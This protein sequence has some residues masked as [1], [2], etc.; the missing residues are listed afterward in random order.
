MNKAS[1]WL[2]ANLGTVIAHIRTKKS[3]LTNIYALSSMMQH[4]IHADQ[5]F[6][7]C[8]IVL[9]PSGAKRNA[10]SEQNIVLRVLYIN[11]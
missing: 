4:K 11:H 2:I 5:Y 9:G 10:K 1:N 6:T 8:R 3:T 7:S